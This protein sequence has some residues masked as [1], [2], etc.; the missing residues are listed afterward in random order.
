MRF[1]SLAISLGLTLGSLSTLAHDEHERH[2]PGE[3][4]EPG[5][6]KDALINTAWASVPEHLAFDIGL[7][8]QYENDP[9]FTYPVT[10]AGSA[11]DRLAPLVENRLT[12]HVTGAIAFFDW[13]QIGIDVPLMLFQQRDET[14]VPAADQETPVGTFGLGD[15]RLYP[16]ARVLQQRDGG[17]LDIGFQVPVSLPTG[18]YTDYFGEQGF[19]FTPTL[20]AS[21]QWDLGFGTLRAA[22][23]VGTRLRT[24]DVALADGQNKASTELILRAGVGYVFLVEEDRPTEIALSVANANEVLSFVEEVP[25]RNPL[26]LMGELTHNVWGP[27]DLTLG[28]SVGLIA[29]NGGPDYRVFA[30][31]RYSPRAPLDK[32]GDGVND[33]DDKCVTVA[34]TKNGFEDEDGCPDADD[35]DGDGIR[36]DADKCPDTAEDKDGFEDED[37][38]IDDDNDKDGIK[39]DNDKCVAEPEDKD[40][41]EDEDGCP[42]GD[43]DKDGIADKDDKCPLEAEDK[44]T[45]EDD[46]GCPDTDN[47]KDSVLDVS[48]KCP[49]EAGVKD[50]RG[51][52]DTDRDGDTVVDRLDNCPDE[53]GDPANGGCVKKQLV[54]IRAEKLEILDKVF[55]KTGKDIIESKSFALLDNVAAVIVSHPDIKKVRVEGHTDNV[56]KDEDNKSLSDRRAKAV[57][58]YLTDKGVDAARLEGVGYGAEKPVADN[59]TEDGKAQNRRV[60]FVIV[61]E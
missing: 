17:I 7:Q 45:F 55:F 48:D 57:A 36:D 11:L 49:L 5:V 44:D 39:N 38:C 28:G 31:A 29:G 22:G 8:L 35:R 3:R 51:C 13:V 32:D 59:A 30:G 53:K 60:E 40:G 12:T 25:T 1:F 52:P 33:K 58:K 10:N 9:L 2:F 21:R 14:R 6:D 56:G 34:E 18:Q 54:V 19:T 20:L 24:L 41:F 46:D 16:K 37:G 4:F 42:D 27:L 47:D 15:I 43:N 50:N 26:E 61:Q 23:N